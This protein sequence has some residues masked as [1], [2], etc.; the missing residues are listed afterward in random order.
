MTMTEHTPEVDTTY[1]PEA[2]SIGVEGEG[3]LNKG[4][5]AF[6]TISE[7][8][9]QLQVPQHVLRLWETQFHQVRPLKRGGGQRYY[10]PEDVA[11]LQYI[12]DLLYNQGY[13]P[14]G[15]QRQL[16]AGV[17]EPVV[18]VPE[19]ESVDVSVAP[20]EQGA[21]AVIE[22]AQESPVVEQIEE[23]A[24]VSVPLLLDDAVAEAVVAIH[25]EHERLRQDLLDILLELESL[26]YRLDG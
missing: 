26:R 25:L 17:P 6:Q 10:R 16:E 23:A 19:P 21:V 9:E 12:A 8:A 4:A 11:L 15:V 13:T 1:A 22:E 14:K 5:L 20:A 3:G 24:A 18:P 7:V 2:E